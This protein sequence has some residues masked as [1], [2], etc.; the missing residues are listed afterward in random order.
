[1]LLS[2]IN[3]V[4]VHATSRKH[5]K[6]GLNHFATEKSDA[7]ESYGLEAMWSK[8]WNWL[9][10]IEMGYQHTIFTG[11]VTVYLYFSITTDT[12]KVSKTRT[13][14]SNLRSFL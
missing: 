4:I 11:T 12:S 14:S 1:M 5:I 13:G 2:T 10:A 8:S 7:L 9:A 6:K 3:A